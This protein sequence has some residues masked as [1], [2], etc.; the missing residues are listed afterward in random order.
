MNQPSQ[1]LRQ[2]QAEHERLILIE[3]IGSHPTRTEQAAHLGISNATLQRKLSDYDLLS[4][5]DGSKQPE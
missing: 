3:V 1:P 4:G 5:Q 2:H